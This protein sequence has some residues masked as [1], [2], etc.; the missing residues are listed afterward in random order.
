MCWID[1]WQFE[2]HVMAHAQECQADLTSK[3][4]ASM[5][6][7][8]KVMADMVELNKGAK[9]DGAALQHF[10][11]AQADPAANA[12]WGACLLIIEA[13]VLFNNAGMA[14]CHRARLLFIAPV[15]FVMS[16]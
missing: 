10:V 14:V 1:T 6:N 9:F 16:W 8:R 11:S 3:V 12:L 2:V 5:R 4:E 15:G 13:L 7:V